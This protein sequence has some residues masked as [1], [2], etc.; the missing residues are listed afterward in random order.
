METL[1]SPACDE[2]RTGRVCGPAIKNEQTHVDDHGQ[3]RGEK[4]PP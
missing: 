3:E 4:T 1:E 2:K